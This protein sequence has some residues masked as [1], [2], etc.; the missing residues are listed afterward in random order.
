VYFPAGDANRRPEKHQSLGKNLQNLGVSK[1]AAK[2]AIKKANREVKN[3]EK[4]S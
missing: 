4:Q 2:D 1:D 3:A